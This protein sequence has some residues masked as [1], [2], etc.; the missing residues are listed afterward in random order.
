VGSGGSA[1][2]IS[3]VYFKDNKMSF[4]IPPQWDREDKDLV[5]EAILKDGKLEGTMNQPNGE[6]VNWVGVKAP[7]LIKSKEPIFENQCL[8]SMV[9]T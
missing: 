8:F 6:V 5:V 2:P 3:I 9:K 1:R 4:S 7:K